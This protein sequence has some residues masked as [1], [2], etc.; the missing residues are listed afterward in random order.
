[1]KNVDN[2]LQVIEHDPLAGWKP[3]N[4]YGANGMILSQTRFNFVRDCF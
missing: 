4:R 2:D 1:M 3:I